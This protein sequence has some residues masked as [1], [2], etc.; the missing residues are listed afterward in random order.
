M[1]GKNKK[2]PYFEFS[3]LHF[4]LLH[5]MVL[6]GYNSFCFY[7]LKV[8]GNHTSTKFPTDF[9]YFVSLLHIL[10]ITTKF[11]AFHCYY[12]CYDDL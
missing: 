6:H 5:F 2:I 8:C 12:I 9:S 3:M 4:I 11:Q 1:G 7:K 10:I